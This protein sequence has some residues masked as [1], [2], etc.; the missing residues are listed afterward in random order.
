MKRVTVIGSGFGGLAIAIRLQ[1][2]GYEV[3]IIEKNEMV[4]GHAYQF[5]ESGYTFDMGPSL[6]TA[7][8]IIERI[9]NV[10]GEKSGDYLDFQALDPFYR[11]YFHDKTYID[12]NGDAVKMKEQMAKF[13]RKDAEKYDEFIENSRKIYEE[14]IVKGLGAVP[15][16]NLSTMAKFVPKALKIKAFHT[17]F[18]LASKYFEDFRHKF[19]FSFHPLFIGGNPF[20][21]PAIYLMISYLEKS[22][23]VW[24]TK[25]GMYSLVT[26]LKNV[27]EKIGGKIITGTPV[28]QILTDGNKAIGVK[29]GGMDYLSDIVVSNADVTHT[30]G[31]LIKSDKNKKWTAPKFDSIKYSMGTVV[32]YLGVKKKYPQLLHHTL[33]L[34]PRYKELIDDIF[35]NNVLPDDFSMYLHVPTRTDPDMAPEGCE[36]IYVLIPVTN[37][38]A[39]IDWKQMSR[40]FTN[41]V[42]NFLEAEFDLVDLRKNI[43]VERTYTPLDFSLERN[44]YLGTPWGMEP[45]LLQTAY[46]R[47]HNKSEDFENL[48]LVGAGTHPGGGIPGVML[49]AEATE[50]CIIEDNK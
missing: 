24:F 35:D 29:A 19:M 42:I 23:G 26:A 45:V 41:K 17:A 31:A 18:G 25:G 15:F 50:N 43:E 22:G 3:T 2:R 33:I 30:Y 13:N 4:G 7:P 37:M 11:I 47:P 32:I 1:A 12:Y 16:T 10:A 27:F 20:R 21:V 34:S 14:V 49:S 8:E 36:S 44:S 38:K 39:N 6:V 5:S 40:P 9:F 46:F 48:Y 28:E